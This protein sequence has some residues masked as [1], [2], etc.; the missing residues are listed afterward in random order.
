MLINVL[1]KILLFGLFTPRCLI[2]PPNTYFYE[3]EKYNLRRDLYKSKYSYS[4]N[5]TYEHDMV[6]FLYPRDLQLFIKR[7]RK[8]ISDNYNEKVRFYAIGEYGTQSLRPHWHLLLFYSSDKLFRDFE[9]VVDLG[10]T[11][12]PCETALFLCDLWEYGITSSCNTD[13]KAFYYVS[14]YVNKPA[15]FPSFLNEFAPQKAY[16]SLFLGQ[17]C[18]EEDTKEQLK[19]RDF[20]SVGKESVVSSDGSQ[21]VVSVRRSLLSRLLPKFSG[22]D[23]KDTSLLHEQLFAYLKTKELGSSVLDQAYTIYEA[24]LNSDAPSPVVKRLVEIFS[25]QCTLCQ[26]SD[27]EANLSSLTSAIYAS[28]RFLCAASEL[29]IDYDEYFQIYLD[30]YKWLGLKTLSDFYGNLES[31]PN[32]ASIYY[33]DFRSNGVVYDCL[34]NCQDS[35][36]Y[37]RFRTKMLERHSKSIKHRTLSDRYKFLQQ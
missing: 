13:G 23:F 21:F 20:E 34:N 16:H 18:K 28:R 24:F 29:E 35:D 19:N 15:E 33:A 3:L 31:S 12:K 32:D 4:N 5:I 6:A 26:Y 10:T 27:N 22:I 17:I 9:D 7:L 30:Y 37:V 2:T 1:R 14:S 36:I 11:S 25:Y 8:Y